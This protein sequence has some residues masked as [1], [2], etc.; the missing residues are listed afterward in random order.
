M[1]AATRLLVRRSVSNAYRRRAGAELD[2]N[3]LTDMQF[4]SV[5][6]TS[7]PVV[8]WEATTNGVKTILVQTLE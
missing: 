6:N 4:V 1:D 7:L 3:G 8:A 2:E 5:K